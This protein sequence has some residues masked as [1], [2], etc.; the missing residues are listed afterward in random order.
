MLPHAEFHRRSLLIGWLCLILAAVVYCTGLGSDHL[1]T[2]GD[3]LLYAQIAK[4]TAA[5]GDLLPLVSPVDRLGNTKPPLLFWQGIFST[6]WGE[7]WKLALLRMPN[8]IYTLLTA[9][10]LVLIGRVRLRNTQLGIQ[11]A[12]LF[13]CFFSTY[14]YGRVFLTSAPETFWLF[15]P[16]ALL[17][18]HREPRLPGGL[19]WPWVW[20]GMIGVGLLYKSFAL[21]V[22]VMVT[23]ALWQLRAEGWSIRQFLIRDL[24][25]LSFVAVAALL[26]FGL[27]F[28]LDPEP[29][30]VLRDFVLRENAGKFDTGGGNYLLNLLWGQSS[31]WRIA[32]SYPLNAGLLA[33]TVVAIAVDAWIRRSHLGHVEVFLWIWLLVL[34]G[35]FCLPNQRDERYLIPAMPALALLLALR[36]GHLPRWVSLISVIAAAVVLAGLAALALL[37][38]HAAGI[39]SL[40]PLWVTVIPAAGVLLAA[41]AFLS[42]PWTRPLLPVVLLWVY[43]GYAAFLIP[44]DR[45]PG[46]FTGEGVESIAGEEVWVPSNFNAREESYAFLLPGAIVHPYDHRGTPPSDAVFAVISR[47]LGEP[48]PEGVVLARRLNMIDRFDAAETRDILMGNVT[49]NL[50]RWDWLVQGR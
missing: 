20:G 49:R 31:I 43:L 8:V 26:L 18:L 25:R 41:W 2:N 45:G 6:G 42:A 15:L 47:R 38:Q 16:L 7:H 30:N 36:L 40:Y 13:L 44:L 4:L 3:E 22:P 39:G 17:L 34:A 27:W 28:W 9:G 35:F 19:L 5:T 33:P 50:F 11:A 32:V 24:W 10:L 37:L 14:R 23:M 48:A 12:L 46:R 21:L 29:M 1:A